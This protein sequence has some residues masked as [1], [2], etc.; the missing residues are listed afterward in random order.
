MSLNFLAPCWNSNSL[1][2][3][4]S[5]YT[6]SLMGSRMSKPCH[7]DETAGETDP[8]DLGLRRKMGGW[9]RNSFDRSLTFEPTSTR[10][11][12]Q[13]SEEWRTNRAKTDS[14]ASRTQRRTHQNSISFILFH[15]ISDSDSGATSAPNNMSKIAITSSNVGRSF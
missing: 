4:T 3:S 8:F 13:N 7:L 11:G 6:A 9:M 1:G 14:P 15:H 2:A 10:E 5:V 12:P